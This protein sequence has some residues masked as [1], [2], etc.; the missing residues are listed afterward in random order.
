MGFRELHIGEA[1]QV[2][3]VKRSLQEFRRGRH[4]DLGNGAVVFRHPQVVCL[5]QDLPASPVGE[6]DIK[7][8]HHFILK[9]LIP[10]IKR[11]RSQFQRLE[12]GGD[13]PL[14][15]VGDSNIPPGPQLA[16]HGPLEFLFH[17]GLQR[18]IGELGKAHRLDALRQG[19]G[20]RKLIAARAP[21][22]GAHDDEKGTLLLHGRRVFNATLG[23]NE[24]HQPPRHDDFAPD[25]LAG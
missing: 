8:Q 7:G 21:Q 16:L 20:S 9:H 17:T 4:Q 2:S 14:T 13:H 18:M 5:P 12:L 3:R 10:A 1:G 19:G 22:A 11:K 23:D 24:I 25:G 15:R 6:L